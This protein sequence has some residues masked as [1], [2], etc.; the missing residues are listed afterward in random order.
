MKPPRGPDVS[1]DLRWFPLV[2]MLQLAADMV[3]GTAPTGFGHEF[4]P[5]DY[6]EAWLALAEPEG[7]TPTELE[8]L[9]KVFE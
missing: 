2:T 3:V 7:W 5:S 8:R 9:R 4:A 6:I 1:P